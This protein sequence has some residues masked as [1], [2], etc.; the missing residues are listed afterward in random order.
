MNTSFFGIRLRASLEGNSTVKRVFPRSKRCTVSVMHGCY[1]LRQA[2]RFCGQNADLLRNHHHVSASGWRCKCFKEKEPPFSFS[3]SYFRPLWKEG[4]LLMRASA[5]TAVISGLFLLLWFG[6][7]K[8]K[9]FVEANILPSVCS[10]VSECIQHDVCFGKVTK[11]S[12]LSVTLESCS[13]GPSEEEFSCGE[14]PTVKVRFRPLASLWRGKFVFDAVL[15]HACVMVVQKKDYSWLGI[16]LSEE[17]TQWRLS[18]EE[19]LDHRTR[20]R[21]VAREEAAAKHVKER[22]DAAREAAEMGYFVSEKNCGP[23]KGDDD[24]KEIATHSAEGTNSKGFFCVKEGEQHGHRCV[25]TG[26]DYDMKHADLEKSF[27]VKFPGKGLLKFWSRII[28]GHKHKSE[29]K[30][31]RSDISASGIALRKKILERGAFAANAYF[32]SKSYGKFEQPSSSSRCFHSRDHDMQLVKSDVDKKAVSVASAVDNRNNDNQNGTQFRDM[33]IW[34]PSANENINGHANDLKFYSDLPSKTRESKLENLQ[35][36]EDVAEHANANIST[37]KTEELGHHVAQRPIDVSTTKGQRDLVSVKQ[38]SQLATYIEVPFKTLIKKFGFTSCF[39]NIEG[40][41]SLFLPGSIEKLKSEMGLKVEDTVSENVD[42]VDVLQFEGLNKILPVTFDSV[43]V[44]GATVMLLAYGDRE[45]RVMENVNGQMMFRNHYN[46]IK[47][48]LSGNCKT[49]RSDDK[50]E[51]DGWLSVDVFVDTIEQKWHANLKTDHLFV[52]LFERVLDIP[53]TWYKG[54]ASGEV[55]LCMSKGE[56]FPNLYGQ[57]DVTGLNFQLSDAPSCFSNTSGSLCF[58]GQ[59]IFLHNASGWF[60]SI[61]LEASGDFGIHPE[62]GEFHL[63]CQ[64]PTVEVNALMRTFNMSSLLFPL[65]GS[66]TALFNCQGPLD[67]PI[68]VGTGMLSR[69]FSSLHVE[70]PTTEA[71]E[72]LAKST[73]AGALAVFDRVPFSHASAN[74]T[75]NT[76][77]CIADLYGI[78]ASLVDGGEIQGAGTVWICSE[79]LDDDTA[80]DANFSGSFILEKIMLRYVPSYHHLMPLKFGVLNGNTKLS[81]SLLRPRFDIKW[82]AP[83]AEGSLSDAR[84][85]IIISHS[86]ITVNFA[87]AAFDLYLKVQTS[88]SD[89]FSLRREE[90]NAPR[91]IPFIVGGVDFDLHM[92]GFEFFSLVTPYML[93]FPRPLILK[94]AGRVKFQGNLLKPS[95]TIIKQNFDKNEKLHM[96]EKGSSYRLVGEVSISGLKV[97]QLMLAPQLS[98]SLSVSPE[99]IKLNASGRS[100]E[101]LVVDYV[102]PLQLCGESGLKSGTVLC[103]SLR[104]G[105]LRANVD[106]RPCYS[107]SLEVCHFPLNELE[108]ASLRGTIRRAEIQLN[109]QK[110]RGHGIISVLSPKF[111]GVIGEALDVAA[112]WSGDVITIEKT[113]LEQSHSYYEI[114]GEYVLPGTRDCIPVDIKGDGILERFLS[115]HLGSVISSMGRWRMKLVVPRAEVA[116][117]LPLARLLSQSMDPA[118]LSRS[119]ILLRTQSDEAKIKS[120][121]LTGKIFFIRSLQS[122]GL[123]SMSIQEL[124]ELIRELHVPSNNVLENL[125]LPGL[126]E[127]KGCW[128]GS[129]NASGGGNGDTLAEFDFHG[130]D[131]EWGEHRTQCVSA[132]GTYS[133]DDGLH[134]KK[135]LVQKDNATIHA[136][137]TFLGPK[138]DLHFAVLNFPVSL[139]PTLVQIIDNAANDVAHSLRQLLAPIKGILHMEGNLR[140]SLGKPECDV[141][142]RLLDGVIGGIVLD[143]AEVVASLTPTNRFL[144]NAKFEP[145]IQNGHVRLQGSIPVNFFQ[146]KMLQQDVELDKSRDTWVPELVK[147]NNIG[148]TT[149]NHA[150]EKKVSWHR[151]EKGWN[152]QLAES[153][154]GLNWQTL[155][156]REVRVDVDI[157]DGGMMLVTALSP[158]ANWLHGSADIMLEARGT[159]DQPVLNGYASFRKATIS[160]PVFQ[161]SLTNFGGTVHM[162][163]NRLSISSLESRLGRKGKLLV[164]GNLPLRTKEGALDDKIEFKCEVLEVR[165]KSILSGQVNSQ[166]QIT[167]SIL[168]PNISGNIKLSRGEVYLPHDRGGSSPNRFPSYQSAL[169]GGGIDKSFASRYIPQY[170]GSESASPMTKISQSSGSGNTLHAYLLV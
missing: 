26:I 56:S 160:S 98:G 110:R 100:D 25:D 28:K 85:D 134:L 120:I 106:F 121:Y 30:A 38:M 103:I 23:S 55:H 156:V 132:V 7:N 87:S 137:G 29:R 149:T 167:G 108:L 60:G 154:K 165:A 13:F 6:R 89:N 159:V 163:S 20:V 37:E 84:G 35:S 147:K 79:A 133:N 17:G 2:F 112:R 143:R 157:K 83:T 152:T 58:R 73:E 39:R 22:D 50:S 32:L 119:K 24:L 66:M 9:G 47:L 81:G 166:V 101:S 135:I 113:V 164:K 78:R 46:R 61:P 11:I 129:L 125:S 141:Q 68:F 90:F 16:P 41:T 139:I 95:T 69:T 33:E 127:L 34:S 71:S 48:K 109:L 168:Q 130:E 65:A 88:Y 92:H 111:S 64:V 51:G 4:L 21:R 96:L 151:N 31:K 97:N 63:V 105:Q 115:E 128:H 144:F 53:I 19:G 15:T 138:T 136:D 10:M 8:A 162:K 43:H 27:R 140:G 67:T 102:G 153:L 62:K 124:L 45:V 169:P 150:R 142:I 117:M 72:V 75:F 14:A 5:Y 40:L 114:Q 122:T 18:T 42:R 116:E 161:N 57:L 123:H 155:D 126:L 77:N 1:P 118:V 70:T 148:S 36:S 44:R 74:F 82:T 52:S 158:C 93:D 170:F 104:K 94:A 107:A 3:L 86:F 76:D 146:S 59:S 145:L 80:I 99:Y 54:R 91:T 49:W 131:W 12:P